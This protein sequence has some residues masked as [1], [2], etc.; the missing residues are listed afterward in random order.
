MDITHQFHDHVATLDFWAQQL[1][2]NVKWIL[3]PEHVSHILTSMSTEIDLLV[4]SVGSSIETQH[5]SFGVMIGTLTGQSLVEIR[6]PATG[7]LHYG[8]SPVGEAMWV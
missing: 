2:S 5:M 7:L 3:S 6:G 1:L 4:V 8:S